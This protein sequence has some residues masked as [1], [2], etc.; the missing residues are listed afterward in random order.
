MFFQNFKRI[1]RWGVIN[2]LRNGI[3]SFSS[4]LV[5]TVALLMIGSTILL[6]VFL[7]ATLM[8]VEDKIDINVY[9]NVDAEEESILTLKNS[10]EILPEI[11][12]VTYVSKDLA[13]EEFKERHKNDELTIQALKELED[14]PLRA[15]FN[16]KA[17][18]PEQYDSIAQM[19]EG[20]TAISLQYG[21]GFIDKVNYR[22]NKLVIERMKKIIYGVEQGGIITTI[23]LIFISILI[24][25]NTIR[26]AI[27]ISKD[28][29][30]VMRLVGAGKMYIR[31]P[32]VVAGALYGVVASLI[33]IGLFY[34]I[35]LSIKQHTEDL[36]GGIDLFRYY[37]SN[38]N[39][40]F[41][42]IL[43]SGILLGA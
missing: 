42:I 38:F 33:T 21:D 2:F 18:S 14:N 35:T 40:I 1:F 25:F 31:G 4:V 36:Y 19:L 22:D 9:F 16:I 20:D 39:Q 26:L 12:S 7:N 34:P 27:Y 41:L 5:M 17:V 8:N 6:S 3:V 10:L 30:S 32:F 43:I 37:I 15:R 24:T 11:S 13:L 23:V 29:I 28:E